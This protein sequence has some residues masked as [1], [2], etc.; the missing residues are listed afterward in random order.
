MVRPHPDK[1]GRYQVAYGHRRL[2]AVAKLGLNIRAVVRKLTDAELV[3][4]QGQENNAR[5]DLSFIEK[6]RFAAELEQQGYSRSVICGA[7][8]VTE[9]N[10]STMISIAN[11]IPRDIIYAVGKAPGVGRPRWN[12]L[13]TILKEK[14]KVKRALA[15]IKDEVFM[16]L[17]SDYV[18]SRCTTMRQRKSL[19]GTLPS[20][21]HSRRTLVTLVVVVVAASAQPIPDAQSRSTVGT[22][23]SFQITL[24]VGLTRYAWSMMPQSRLQR[25]LLQGRGLPA[26]APLLSATA[27]ISDAQR[28]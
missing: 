22:I 26:L 20:R 9:N 19:R 10:L 13:L 11:R 15:F 2:K 21:S 5:L 25:R 4:A 28:S 23:L 17:P 18:L 16:S 24:C 7:L 12:D 8:V 6:A 3:V 1:E 14:D 27:W